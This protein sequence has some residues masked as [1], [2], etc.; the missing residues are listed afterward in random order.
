MSTPRGRS[1]TRPW[2]RRYGE[3]SARRRSAR[4]A[5]ERR[6]VFFER[7]SLR[8]AHRRIWHFVERARWR[9]GE[10]DCSRLGT[11]AHPSRSLGAALCASRFA[12]QI[13]RTRLFLSSRVRIFSAISEAVA[14]PLSGR[15]AKGREGLFGAGDSS[16]PLASLGAALRASRF[17][18]QICR[19]QAFLISEGSNPAGGTASW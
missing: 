17:A 19:T 15:G 10:R 13:C 11:A 3:A 4:R 12:P 7:P 14:T 16:S 5:R 1:I 18:L 8:F 2:W 9:R 6:T